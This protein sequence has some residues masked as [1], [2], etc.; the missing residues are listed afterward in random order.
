MTKCSLEHVR[1]ASSLE[2]LAAGS[3]EAA[4]KELIEGIPVR[5]PGGGEPVEEVAD[6][7]NAIPEEHALPHGGA[8][9]N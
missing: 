8:Q 3:W 2:Q 1:A 4:I 5:D 9:R 7:L 6:S